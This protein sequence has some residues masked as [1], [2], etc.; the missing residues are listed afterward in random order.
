MRTPARRPARALAGLTAAA[1]LVAACGNDGP[2]GA[3]ATASPERAPVDEL[4][5]RQAVGAVDASPPDVDL[6][7][8]DVPLAEVVFDTFDGG[9][10]RLSESDR[11]TRRRLLDVIRPIDLPPYDDLAADPSAGAWLRPD[12][13]VVGYIADGTPIAYP[14]KILNGHEIV[15]D[16]LAGTAVLVT[17]C[18]LCHSAVVYDRRLPDGQLLTF[19]NTSALHDSD[20]VMV[21]R[22]TGS[23]WWQVAGRAIVG[24]LTGAEL[25][26]LPSEMATWSD[27]LERHPDTLV[28]SRDLGFGRNYERNS[29]AGYEERVAEGRFAFP[30]GDAAFD[31]RLPLAELVVVVELGDQVVAYAVDDLD[32]PLDDDVDGFGIRVTPHAGGASVVAID[33]DGDGEPGEPI[34]SRTAFW[35]SV[36]GA[37]PDVEVRGDDG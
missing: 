33:G 22:E 21:D 27:W 10:V 18:P 26:T 2:E 5:A 9:F 11:D 16:E 14:V 29:F 37:F 31:D 24:E 23:Y 25:A 19:S 1:L 28:L 4:T 3:S 36:A 7:M 30:V 20:M 13:L 35:F 32:Q 6:S 17:Y 34:P 15:N 8:H 12:D